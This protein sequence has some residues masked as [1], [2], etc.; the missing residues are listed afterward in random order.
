MGFK[1]YPKIFLD[2]RA[3]TVVEYVLLIAV[4]VAVGLGIFKSQLFRDY[5]GE[6]GSFVSAYRSELEYSYKFGVGGRGSTEVNY[7]SPNHPS[8]RSQG[9]TRFFGARDEYPR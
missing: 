1:N 6:E 3:Q 5:F 7:S 8:F 9:Q 2:N 4:V